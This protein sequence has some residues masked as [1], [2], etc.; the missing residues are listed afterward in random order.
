MSSI[1]V[2]AHLVRDALKH[3]MGNRAQG[4]LLRLLLE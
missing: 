1:P 2:G 3:A 4:A